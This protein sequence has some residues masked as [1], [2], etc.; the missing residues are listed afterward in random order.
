MKALVTISENDVAPRFDLAT[1]VL[2]V[3]LHEY[4]SNEKIRTVVLAHASAEDLC[5]LI[6][7]EGVNVV[8]CGGIEEEYFDYLSWKRI[9]VIDSVMGPWESSLEAFR[10]GSLRPGSILFDRCERRSYGSEMAP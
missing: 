10:S 6:L 9:Q 2:I 4:S 8:V 7:S 5:Q 1:E 3:S